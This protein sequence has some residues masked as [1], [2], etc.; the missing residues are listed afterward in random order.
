MSVADSDDRSVIEEGRSGGTGP[1][2]NTPRK[3]RS[4]DDGFPWGRCDVKGVP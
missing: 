4:A 1:A 2:A 3:N